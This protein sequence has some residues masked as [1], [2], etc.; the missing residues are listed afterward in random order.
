MPDNVKSALAIALRRLLRPLVRIMLREGF[1]YS[2]FAAIAQM[3]FV[4]CAAKDFESGPRK[5]TG[6]AISALTGI[7][8]GQLKGILA[9]Q[10]QFESSA[11]LES[12][13][14]FARV[15]HGWHNDREY[16]GPYGFPVDIPF[17][18][19]NLSLTAL[20]ARHAPGVSPHAVLH[21]LKR[22]KAVTEVGKNIWKPI[23]QEYIEPT[24][25]AENIKRMASLAESLF[26]TI[27]R[28][29]RGGRDGSELFERTMVVDEPLTVRQFLALQD[30]LKVAG[31]QFLHR[32]DAF[33]AIDLKEKMAPRPN[34]R[35]EIRAGLQCFLYVEPEADERKLKDI[36]DLDSSPN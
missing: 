34:E 35:G 2:H 36:V 5:V 28:N 4:D 26:T 21:E 12:S 15:L 29:T 10:A 32:I 17:E 27:E 18:G 22:V 23:V 14:P 6:S 11:V 25:S 13:N 8:L 9:E 19:S 24:L 31:A 3:T 33:A 30:H 20:T 16:V 7:S 1:T